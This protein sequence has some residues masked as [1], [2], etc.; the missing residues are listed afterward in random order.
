MESQ[1]SIDETHLYSME[2]AQP[3]LTQWDVSWGP[4]PHVLGPGM[5]GP[6]QPNQDS[7]RPHWGLPNPCQARPCRALLR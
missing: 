5:Q 4:K 7:A 1:L 3:Y 2:A 6:S